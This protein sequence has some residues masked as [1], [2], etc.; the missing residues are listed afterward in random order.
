MIGIH[1]S[2]VFTPFSQKSLCFMVCDLDKYGAISVKKKR[3]NLNH[4][5]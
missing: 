4:K 2:A 1:T 5:V 3:G